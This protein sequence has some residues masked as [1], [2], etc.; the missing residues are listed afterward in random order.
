MIVAGGLLS[1][2]RTEIL[3][4]SSVVA[5]CPFLA[6]DTGPA[7]LIGMWSFAVQQA[8]LLHEGVELCLSEPGVT[9]CK[10]SE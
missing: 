10:D 7:V 4:D 8:C 2:I 3:N 1:V 5:L 6:F 9:N